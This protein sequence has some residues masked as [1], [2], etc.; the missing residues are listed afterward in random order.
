MEREQDI[1]PIQIAEQ[2][3][4]LNLSPRHCS[5]YEETGHFPQFVLCSQLT[6]IILCQESSQTGT[7]KAVTKRLLL[8]VCN[9]CTARYFQSPGGCPL[10]L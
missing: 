4:E 2:T 3:A 10:L 9:G 5:I 6:E 1:L 7:P 8:G